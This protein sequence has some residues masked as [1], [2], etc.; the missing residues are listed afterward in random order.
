M[1]NKA[2]LKKILSAGIHV[3]DKNKLDESLEEMLN[4]GSNGNSSS[5][6]SGNMIIYIDSH[7]GGGDNY[8]ADKTFDEIYEAIQ[9]GIIPI[10][11]Y[12][13]KF[14]YLTYLDETDY[15]TFVHVSPYS[16]GISFEKIDID[17]NN[18][19]YMFYYTVVVASEGE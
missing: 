5:G 16:D 4:G 18:Y 13:S 19:V 2:Y 7:L 1:D 11:V 15:C 14:Y 12:D 8:I 10:C 6:G 3:A 9:Q 17:N